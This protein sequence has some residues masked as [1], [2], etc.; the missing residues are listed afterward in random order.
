MITPGRSLKALEEAQGLYTAAS[1]ADLKHPVNVLL[2]AE[3]E[4]NIAD[5]QLRTESTTNAIDADA[6]NFRDWYLTGDA[7]QQQVADAETGRLRD[8]LTTIKTMTA[9][10]FTPVAYAAPKVSG[11]WTATIAEYIKRLHETALDIVDSRASVK[12]VVDQRAVD[13][14]SVAGLPDYSQEL[15]DR[16]DARCAVWQPML[17]HLIVR[18]DPAQPDPG[19]WVW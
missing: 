6:K 1:M 13:A 2:C 18:L 9:S 11:V 10:P 8:C 15:L 5:F 12:T 3:I 4:G 7:L 17:N 14:P 19:G 16:I